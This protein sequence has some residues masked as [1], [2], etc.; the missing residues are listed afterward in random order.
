[1]K[2]SLKNVCI[3]FTIKLRNLRE[4]LRGTFQSNVLLKQS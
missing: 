3:N 4:I 2:L 1:M